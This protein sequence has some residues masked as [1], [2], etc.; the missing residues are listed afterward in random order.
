MEDVDLMGRI[1]K[2]GGKVRVLPEKVRTSAR[3]WEQDGI[4]R[5]TLRNWTLQALYCC[6]VSPAR[7]A[8]FYR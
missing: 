7:L 6:G 3:R 2:R 1:R 8:R 5:G 4:V